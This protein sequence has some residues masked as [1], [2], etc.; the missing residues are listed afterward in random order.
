MP[1]LKAITSQLNVLNARRNQIESNIEYTSEK[2]EMLKAP[3]ERQ[4]KKLEL[5][6]DSLKANDCE[7]ECEPVNPSVD[8]VN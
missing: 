1:E 2:K 5:E 6:R 3:I 4:I 8:G 7:V